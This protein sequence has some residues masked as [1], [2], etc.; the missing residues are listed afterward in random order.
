[1]A[2]SIF[3]LHSKLEFL[4]QLLLLLFQPGSERL[5]ALLLL[6]LLFAC[7]HYG[8]VGHLV[9]EE[10]SQFPTTE[11]SPVH[12]LHALLC[13]K[14][15]GELDHYDSSRIPAEY[16]YFLYDPAFTAFAGDV[17]F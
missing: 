11:E 5:N 17:F 1:M 16:S 8:V 9:P 7:V 12:H 4:G 10:A 13:R 15:S 2:A 3:I 14:S 6:L